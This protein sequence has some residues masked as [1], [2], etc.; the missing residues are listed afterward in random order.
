MNKEL[1]ENLK[2]ELNSLEGEFSNPN[3]VCT[4]FL[5]EKVNGKTG[6][7]KFTV[8]YSFYEYMDNK[9]EYSFIK[10]DGWAEFY[11]KNLSE[12]LTYDNIIFN[13]DEIVK[14]EK[15]LDTILKVCNADVKKY[16]Y[17]YSKIKN[18]ESLKMGNNEYVSVY[19]KIK[20]VMIKEGLIQDNIVISTDKTSL[21]INKE[22]EAL[23]NRKAELKKEK[24]Q[25]RDDIF[26]QASSSIGIQKKD[27]MKRVGE[28][29]S[30]EIDKIVIDESLMTKLSSKPAVAATMKKTV[31]D[32]IKYKINSSKVLKNVSLDIVEIDNIK[33]LT[34]NKKETIF[35]KIASSDNALVRAIYNSAKEKLNLLK[36]IVKPSDEVKNIVKESLINTNSKVK[37]KITLAKENAKN[38]IDEKRENI[39]NKVQGALFNTVLS[40]SDAQYKAHEKL[41]DVKQGINNQKQKLA[42]DA[43]N[44]LL[45]LAF[46][47]DPNAVVLNAGTKVASVANPML[48]ETAGKNLA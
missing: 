36:M 32:K 7:D 5:S 11:C 18:L 8:I 47:I 16:F 31:F 45:G 27:L 48:E 28:N 34:I 35:D 10:S 4:H 22:I 44:K 43:A 2:N 15:L 37:E 24:V 20:E 42:N 23:N 33:T 1:Y 46:K 38:S 26:N 9:E 6:K 41:D 3:Y 25:R 29:S 14:D 13:F 40:V 30:F 21:G 12:Y 17:N 39:N 19:N